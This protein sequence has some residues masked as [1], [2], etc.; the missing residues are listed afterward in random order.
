[1]GAPSEWLGGHAASAA[2]RAGAPLQRPGRGGAPSTPAMGEAGRPRGSGRGVTGAGAGS[3]G[4]CGAPS[5][6]RSRS[7]LAWA[8]VVA[9]ARIPPP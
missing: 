8:C 6:M 5:P 3:P 7:G 9:A 1:V 4:R 2:A